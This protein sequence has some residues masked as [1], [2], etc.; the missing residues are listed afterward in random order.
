MRVIAGLARGKRLKTAEGLSVRPTA[1]RVKESIFNIIQFEVEDRHVLDLFAG[2]GGLGIEA[3]SRGAADCTFVDASSE[4]IQVI[5]E[6]V[7]ACGFNDRCKIKKDNYDSFVANYNGEPFDLV[8]LDPP[9]SKG[10]VSHAISVLLTCD[11]LSDRVIIMAE[12]DREDELPE[13]V[14]P[15]EQK[16]T[17]CYGKTKVSIYRREEAR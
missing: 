16:K 2:S 4:A 17:Y 1:D 3:L 12:S 5:K 10:M 14:G 15:I 11:I 9:Y 6:N 13:K 8:F 7:A